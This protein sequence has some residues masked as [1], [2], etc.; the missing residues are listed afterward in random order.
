[1]STSWPNCCL[2]WFLS[3]T[4]QG[5][6]GISGFGSAPPPLGS[7]RL[8]SPGPGTPLRAVGLVSPAAAGAPWPA[9]VVVQ[10]PTAPPRASRP[11]AATVAAAPAPPLR[12]PT[13]YGHQAGRQVPCGAGGQTTEANARRPGGGAARAGRLRGAARL[14]PP[15]QR[16]R[17]GDP[18][19]PQGRNIGTKPTGVAARR[20]AAPGA[21]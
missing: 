8:G 11:A 6:S 3:S 1:M 19:R 18:A 9:T 16:H 21:D 7:G 5:E 10:P 13:G 14:R 4:S 12:P 2:N 20:T 17:P 15:G